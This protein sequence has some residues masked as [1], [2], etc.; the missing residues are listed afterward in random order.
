MDTGDLFLAPFVYA[1]L[2]GV[3][4]RPVCVV[5]VERFNRGL[6]V[7]VAM[8]TSRLGRRRNPG[9]GD[10]VIQEWHA[11]GLLAPSTVR[12]GRLQTMEVRLL[13]AHLG[14]LGPRDLDATRA[15]LQAVLGLL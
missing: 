12:T 5:S 4:R 15:A 8:V 14:K 11:P 10:V 7:V 2:V 13:D 6:D 3:K 9:I 1:D